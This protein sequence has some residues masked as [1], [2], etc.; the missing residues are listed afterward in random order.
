MEAMGHSSEPGQSALHSHDL[1]ATTALLL[2]VKLPQH[3]RAWELLI[4]LLVA[5]CLS[6]LGFSPNMGQPC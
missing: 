1:G 5:L 4:V 2:L 3:G 6:S